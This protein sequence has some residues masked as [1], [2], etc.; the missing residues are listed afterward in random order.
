MLIR[1]VIVVI[2]T[3]ALIGTGLLARKKFKD[4]GA[5]MIKKVVAIAAVVVSVAGAGLFIKYKNKY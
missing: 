1:V 5:K 3:I 2:V 4:G